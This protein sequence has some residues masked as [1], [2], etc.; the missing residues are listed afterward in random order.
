MGQLPLPSTEKKQVEFIIGVLIFTWIRF[1]VR[2]FS[3]KKTFSKNKF[4][5]KNYFLDKS[6][7]WTKFFR[8]KCFSKLR[9]RKTAKM[10]FWIFCENEKRRKTKFWNPAKTKNCENGKKRFRATPGCI[11]WSQR[12][13]TDHAR[14]AYWE[15][16]STKPQTV[17]QL[18]L[19]KGVDGFNFRLEPKY[20]CSTE[21]TVVK[22][23]TK[24]GDTICF[25]RFVQG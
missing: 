14:P 13:K 17:E 3:R 11:H 1:L 19:S 12:S 24:N 23:S 25:M 18:K 2:K 16:V 5:S 8:E 22:A 7:S 6:F 20:G 10:I 4:F 15:T 21:N 9:K